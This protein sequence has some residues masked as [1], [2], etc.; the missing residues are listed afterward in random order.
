M[1]EEQW[2]YDKN[3]EYPFER[4]RPHISALKR[5]RMTKK[6]IWSAKIEDIKT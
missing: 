4:K 1:N 2:H 6:N 3:E 5:K